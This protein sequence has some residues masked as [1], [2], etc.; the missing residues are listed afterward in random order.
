MNSLDEPLEISEMLRSFLSPVP[1]SLLFSKCQT[2]QFPLLGLHLQDLVFYRVFDDQ[3]DYFARSGL[4]EAV[5]AVDSLVFDCGSP[6]GVAEDDLARFQC[7]DISV[8]RALVTYLIRSDEVKP[9]RTDGER[10]KH[11]RTAW[12]RV[13][14]LDSRIATCRRHFPV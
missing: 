6:P 12:I 3:S 8:W 1:L 14:C 4:A 10:R 7:G 11:D 9:N 5:H 13:Q 2:S